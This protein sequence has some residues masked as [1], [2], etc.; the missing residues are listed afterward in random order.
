MDPKE[1]Q[2]LYL[3]LNRWTGINFNHYKA[4]QIQ[5]RILGLME[6]RGL[7][8]FLELLVFLRHSRENLSWFIDKLAINFSG[9]FRDPEKWQY[10]QTTILPDLLQ[11]SPNLKIWSAG[12]S[13]GAEPVTLQILLDTYFPGKHSILATDIDHAALEQAR[14]GIFS[15]HD[16]ARVPKELSTRYFE[17][18]EGY[19]HVQPRILEKI[20]YEESNLLTDPFDSDFDLILCRNV[21]IYFTLETQATLYARLYDALKQGGCLFLGS[22]ERIANYQQIGYEVVSPFFYK[23]PIQHYKSW[24]IA[25]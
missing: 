15:Q 14:Q 5:R 22:T 9:L 8:N 16:V 6:A 24:Q 2:R 10:L 7:N 23:K 4:K 18:R 3:T 13:Y 11:R 19:W 12:C 21:A 25:S 20:H 17:F 1:W